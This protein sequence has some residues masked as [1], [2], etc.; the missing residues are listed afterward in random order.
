LLREP[1]DGLREPDDGLRE[2]DGG[3]QEIRRQ[4]LLLRRYTPCIY[5][6]TM[7][8]TV[9][10]WGNSL[11]VRIPRPFAEEVHLEEN[12]TVDLTVRGGKLVIV[13]AEPEL[14]LDALVDQITD[15]NRHEE[16][17]TGKPV[18]NEIW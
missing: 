1:D 16:V 6:V 17:E 7:K 4:W 5:G 13:P 10:K 18:G 8:T 12:S 9:Q 14:T 15:E 2:P 11:A 3:L